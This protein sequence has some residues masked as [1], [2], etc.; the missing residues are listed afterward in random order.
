MMAIQQQQ[1]RVP[2]VSDALPSIAAKKSTPGR[3]EPVQRDAMLLFLSLCWR[4]RSKCRCNGGDCICLSSALC[5]NWQFSLA[6]YANFP[7]IGL[8]YCFGFIL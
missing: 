7:G 1:I 6:L 4:Y 8:C 3:A 2:A 5:L